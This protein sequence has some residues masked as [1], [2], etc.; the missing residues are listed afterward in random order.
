LYAPDN[1]ACITQTSLDF[2][3]SPAYFSLHAHLHPRNQRFLVMS[4]FG[5]WLLNR[6]CLKG[7]AITGRA[8]K[9]SLGQGFGRV[10]VTGGKAVSASL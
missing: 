9:A 6:R 5:Q 3:R 8:L 7:I 10:P 2:K 1:P 4:P